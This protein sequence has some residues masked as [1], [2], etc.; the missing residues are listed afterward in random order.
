MMLPASNVAVAI[1]NMLTEKFTSTIES[2]GFTVS[3][4]SFSFDWNTSDCDK[5]PVPKALWA[6]DSDITKASNLFW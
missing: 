2:K 3:H 6:G 5:L 1:I 4:Y